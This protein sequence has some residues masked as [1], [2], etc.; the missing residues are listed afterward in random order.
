MET[1]INYTVVG[2][3]VIAL[4]IALVT[5][6]VWLSSFWN[7]KSY[8]VYATYLNEAASGL[9]EQSLVRFNGVPIG[10]VSNIALNPNNPQQVRIVMKI[11][12]GTPITTST[13][14][15]LKAWGVTGVNYIEL[16]AIDNKGKLLVAT[17]G[18]KYPVIPSK[19]SLF[20]QLGATLHEVTISVRDLSRSF[21]RV[22]TGKNEISINNSLKNI[23][24]FTK[25]LADNSQRIDMTLKNIQRTSA[26][27][28]QLAK[29]FQMTLKAAQKTADKLTKASKDVSLTMQNSRIVMQNVSQ[30][31]LPR[32]TQMLNHLENVTTNVQ[33]ITSEIRDNPSIIVRGKEPPPPGPGE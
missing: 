6:F 2:I 10:Y 24:K 3:F 16:D 5:I 20:E 7:Q 21:H 1:K 13:I 17:A 18:E 32:A 26:Q 11:E 27:L 33:Q 29:E 25:T 12:K 31:V 22:L 8:N 9:S 15:T 23:S 14:A 19:L 28:P 30:Q 4:L